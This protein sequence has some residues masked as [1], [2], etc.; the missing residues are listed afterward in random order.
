M[1]GEV[2]QRSVQRSVD[3]LRSGLGRIATYLDPG[4]VTLV[5]PAPLLRGWLMPRIG[6]LRAAVPGLCPLL[7]CDESA[8]FV[9]EIDVDIVI[10]DRPLPQASL[11]QQPLLTDAWVT[12]ASRGVA[13]QLAQVPIER[14]PEYTG[15]VCSE[16]DLTSDQTAAVFRGPLAGFARHAIFDD[17]R[18]VLDAVERGEGI[19]CLSQT[20][21]DGGL[22]AGTL[23]A[24]PGYARSQGVT[25]WMSR[26]AGEPRSPYVAQFFDWLVAQGTASAA[27]VN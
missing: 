10:S 3:T 6:A 18:L 5:A 21:A 7:S 13:E 8:R 17:T 25:W 26:V 4:L 20:L 23:V 24:L 11:Q 2:L 19:A 15:V 9:D 22:R 16:Q 1:A 14:H 12:V 27:E